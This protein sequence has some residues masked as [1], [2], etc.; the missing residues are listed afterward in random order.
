MGGRSIRT[1]PEQLGQIRRPTSAGAVEDHRHRAAGAA[2][3]RAVHGAGRR[4]GDATAYPM[5][6][7]PA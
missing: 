4:N 1:Q 5:A 7:G 2:R 3:E 6:R